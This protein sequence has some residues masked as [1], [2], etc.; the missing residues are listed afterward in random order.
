MIDHERRLL[1][2]AARTEEGRISVKRDPDR[3][4]PGDHS[5]LCALENEG[6]LHFLGEQA[7]PHIGGTFAVWQITERGRATLR[8]KEAAPRGRDAVPFGVEA[9]QG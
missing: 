4:W 2:K 3:S 7:G 9:R 8:R 6:H 5:R 1:M